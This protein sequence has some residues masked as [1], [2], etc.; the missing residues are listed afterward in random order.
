MKSLRNKI[1]ACRYDVHR[2]VNVDDE[3]IHHIELNTTHKVWDA[4]DPTHEEV[5]F[6]ILDDCWKQSL[7]NHNRQDI[8]TA[9]V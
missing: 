3:T 2:G 5:F 6:N 9:S 1:F 8:I 7:D 4:C